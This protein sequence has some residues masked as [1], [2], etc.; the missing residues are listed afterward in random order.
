MARKNK[1]SEGKGDDKVPLHKLFSFADRLDIALMAVGT[2]SAVANGVSQPLMTLIFGQLINTFGG[3]DR[4]H[5]V[6]EVSKV[7]FN[8]FSFFLTNQFTFSCLL[9][10]FFTVPCNRYIWIGTCDS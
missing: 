10:T 8:F 6:H 4:S 2:V 9:V 5:V 3:A 7:M 1:A